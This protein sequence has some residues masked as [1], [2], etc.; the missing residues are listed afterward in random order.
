MKHK[1]EVIISINTSLTIFWVGK[2]KT[3]LKMKEQKTIRIKT[4]TKNIG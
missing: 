1:H 2:I 3:N 4:K